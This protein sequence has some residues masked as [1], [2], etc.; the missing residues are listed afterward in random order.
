VP[1]HGILPLAMLPHPVVSIR[2]PVQPSPEA[3]VIP[4]GP[5][6]ESTAHDT[7]VLRIY[8]LLAA[9]AARQPDMRAARNL[10]IRWLENYPRTG[11]DPDV[12]ILDPS[13]SDF[14]D[15]TSL[16]LWEPGRVPPRLCVEVASASHPYKDYTSI[17]ERYAAF[18]TDELVVFDPLLVGPRSLGG[19]VSLQLWRRDATKTFDRVHFGNDPVYS[20]VLDAWFIADGRT[21]HI[22]DDRR[23]TRRWLTDAEQNRVEAEHAQQEAKHAQQEAKHAQQEAK[24]AQQEAQRAQQELE[25]ARDAIERERAAREE[26]ERLLKELQSKR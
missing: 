26:I 9:W 12:C 2:Y 7:A 23:G 15:L 5:V 10:A 8:L 18:G 24:H 21:L 19:P 17:H 4:E 3:W 13:P 16:R 25:R 11:I 6:P 22:A 1:A 20:Q 14:D